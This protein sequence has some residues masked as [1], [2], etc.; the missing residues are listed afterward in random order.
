MPPDFLTE[1]EAFY[2][3]HKSEKQIAIPEA[4]A[5]LI[6]QEAPLAYEGVL[7]ALDESGRAR[8]VAFLLTLFV[9]K[10]PDLGYSSGMHSILGVTL[11]VFTREIHAFCLFSH[12]IENIYPKVKSS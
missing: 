4:F 9:V 11:T 12:L 10:R 6:L 8:R 1:A 5:D 2:Q 7:S 3:S